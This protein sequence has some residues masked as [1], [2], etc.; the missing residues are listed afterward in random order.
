MSN[1]IC[2]SCHLWLILMCVHMFLPP[3]P[4]GVDN[5]R[6]LTGLHETAHIDQFFWG[7]AHRGASIR[8]PRGVAQ[9]SVC[10]YI[11]SLPSH[12]SSCCVHTSSCRV[13]SGDTVVMSLP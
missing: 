7:V 9:G 4:Q 11:H 2:I 3:S 10:S 5:S 6:R 13:G 12:Q 8:I 1:T